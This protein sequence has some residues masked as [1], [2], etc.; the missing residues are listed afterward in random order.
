M[1]RLNYEHSYNVETALLIRYDHDESHLNYLLKQYKG[2]Y[3]LK[4]Y[5]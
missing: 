2:A 5:S 1:S 3:Y 4:K